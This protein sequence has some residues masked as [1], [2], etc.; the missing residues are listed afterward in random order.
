MRKI[1]FGKMLVAL[2]VVLAAGMFAACSS[3][4]D[5]NGTSGGD[6]TPTPTPTPTATSGTLYV[7]EIAL[8]SIFTWTDC[9]FSLE[10]D[11]YKDF[12]ADSTSL[13]K[14]KNATLVAQIKE[15]IT[16]DNLSEL[17]PDSITK[18]TESCPIRIDSVKVTSF[19]A[20]YVLKSKFTPKTGVDLQGKEQEIHIL[21]GYCFID[22]LGA[23][24][25]S[26]M[27]P[28]V[29]AGIKPEDIPNYCKLLDEDCKLSIKISSLNK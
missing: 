20:N 10:G 28:Q 11:N 22:N 5:N 15:H 3:S 17:L 23:N 16:K 14:I 21:L 13:S 29:A 26:G 6:P 24:R 7:Y 1:N 4:D 9:S 8:P 25:D 27:E 2:A 19:P 18:L 12:C